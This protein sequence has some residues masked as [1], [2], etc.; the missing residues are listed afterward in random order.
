MK[1]QVLLALALATA[2][3]GHAQQSAAGIQVKPFNAGQYFAEK[4]K[5]LYA[6]EQAQAPATAIPKSQVPEENLLRSAQSVTV[7]NWK[8]FTGSMNV[9]GVIVSNSKP[10]IFDDD[11]NAVSFVHRKSSTY[12]PN[13]MPNDPGA[14]AGAI[15][16]M[17][18]GDW[19]T[20]W[21]TTLIWNDENLWARY[22]QGGL[23]HDPTHDCIDSAAIIA[24]GP[25]TPIS[26]GWIGSYFASKWLDSIGGAKN[27]NMVSSV[28]GATAF[29][30]NT[31][32]FPSGKFDFPRHD[33]SATD[34][35]MVRTLGWLANDIN[36]TGANYGWQGASVVN[37]THMG[38][39]VF[40]WKADT[41]IP[42]I[43]VN[44]AG[45]QYVM[46]TPHMA[47][48]ESGTVGYVW[49]IGVRDTTGL[50]DSLGKGSNMGYQPIVYKTTNSG[51]SW[52][53]LPRINFNTALN[54]FDA[55]FSSMFAVQGDSI[56]IPYF[57]INEGVD[58]IVD[59]N[60]RLHIVSPVWSTFS[61]HP[62]SL[63]YI[64]VYTHQD[65][66]QYYFR[67]SPGKH[68]YIY[69]F[70]ETPTGWKVTVIDSMSSE[71]PGI[72]P[73]S[74][75]FGDNPWDIG[76]AGNK[77]D[78]D[79]RIQLSRTA[80]GKYIVYTW[81]ESDTAFTSAGRKW[82]TQPNVKAR[83]AEIGL[84]S[85]S[86]P[87]SITIHPNEINITNPLVGSDPAVKSKASMHYISP[88]CAVIS[89]TASSGIAIGLP[90][91]VSNNNLVPMQPLSPV[92]HYYLSAA[93]NF[94]NVS[95]YDFPARHAY[96]NMT[97]IATPDLHAAEFSIFPN[98]AE[99]TVEVTM[100]G[101]NSGSADLVMLNTLGQVVYSA[102]IPVSGQPHHKV[103]VSSLPNGV[104]LV[105][106]HSQG[107]V[108][109]TKLVISH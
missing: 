75:G 14:I 43:L 13:P 92:T 93:L 98:P 90:I 80:D 54:T 101:V 34:D 16:G 103:D 28:P 85:G 29:I 2:I 102:H 4:Y 79:A 95:T 58:G 91:T 8:P 94:D 32:P 61:K 88:K 21:D 84:E 73:T 35:G 46:G 67:H 63:N 68:P 60:D 59:R 23:W 19:G 83:L 76:T 24:M 42:K 37:G 72:T 62:D 55:V 78:S 41:I 48:N 33:F 64:N 106:V 49:F 10:L 105:N 3:G 65:G 87:G 51:G 31:A 107:E 9:Y 45:T 30:A 11:L 82:N 6:P 99:S 22:P 56:G 104:Y 7:P 74:N 66:E 50:P 5:V 17:V 36:G 26:A 18:T 89:S 100:S 44:S 77:V 97:V 70:T 12:I 108:R 109:T 81:A 86:T 39:G 52:T 47:W 69:D 25:I 15:V 53:E 20:E 71:A 27:D 38:G 1:R 96:C 57:T 40:A